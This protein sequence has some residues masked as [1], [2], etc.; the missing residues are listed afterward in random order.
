[1]NLTCIFKMFDTKALLSET[2]PPALSSAYYGGTL[3]K[4][5]VVE[6]VVF[7]SMNNNVPA[8]KYLD[9]CGYFQFLNEGQIQ[10]A[11]VNAAKHGSLEVLHYL[12][13]RFQWNPKK[14]EKGVLWYAAVN[15][16]AKVVEW[17]QQEFKYDQWDVDKRMVRTAIFK[18]CVPVLKLF[19]EKYNVEKTSIL[20]RVFGCDFEPVICNLNKIFDQISKDDVK[21]HAFSILE[22]AIEQNDPWNIFYFHFNAADFTPQ[23]QSDLVFYAGMQGVEQGSARMVRVLGELGFKVGDDEQKMEKLIMVICEEGAHEMLLTIHEFGFLN[24]FQSSVMN[25]YFWIA[26]SRGYIDV[27][28][29]LHQHFPHTDPCEWEYTLEKVAKV[30]GKPGER[31]R[32]MRWMGEHFSLGPIGVEKYLSKVIKKGKLGAIP[33]PLSLLQGFKIHFGYTVDYV[34]TLDNRLLRIAAKQGAVD[35]MVGLKKCFGLN[36]HDVRAKKNNVVRKVRSLAVLKCL[37]EEFGMEVEDIMCANFTL[38][39]RASDDM[40]SY[41]RDFFSEV[42]DFYDLLPEFKSRAEVEAF[43]AAVKIEAR[44]TASPQLVHRASTRSRCKRPRADQPPTTQLPS[45]ASPV[46]TQLP[47]IASPVTTQLPSVGSPVTTQ[48]PSVGSPVT[49]QL[50]SVGSPATTQLPS[51]GS[52]VTTQLPSVANQL[53]TT[54]PSRAEAQFTGEQ[55]SSQQ[56]NEDEPKCN[57]DGAR[58]GRA[59]APLQCKMSPT[60]S[61]VSGFRS[62]CEGCRHK[63]GNNCKRLLKTKN[64]LEYAEED[65]Y[66]ESPQPPVRKRR[67]TRMKPHKPV[68]FENEIIATVLTEIQEIVK[69]RETQIE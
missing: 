46:T 30:A 63:T 20:D 40:L 18:Q 7:A 57:C 28:T 22:A 16:H 24:N 29:F 66:V 55:D 56:N 45:I 41:L 69:Q 15:N 61:S 52:P 64:C 8:F 34:R 25:G 17:L 10:A 62:L 60:K 31:E 12:R 19:H 35:F 47:S 38:L 59:H 14:Q 33:D 50:P 48:L 3:S 13:E 42:V 67:L 5:Q 2:V 23:E 9:M 11:A 51:V 39:H 1:M 53:T 21:V 27:T 32:M 68:D 4:E 44:T 58:C 37:V 36:I 43:I 26:L 6:V 54:E 65:L 49:T